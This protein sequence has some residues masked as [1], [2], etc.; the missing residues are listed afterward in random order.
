VFL[1]FR[2]ERGQQGSLPLG[3]ER[4][5]IGRSSECTIVVGDERVSRVH[6]WLENVAGQFLVSDAESSNGTFLNGLRLRSRASCA[7]REGDV[8]EIGGTRFL[9]GTLD[10][11]PHEAVR[12]MGETP[13]A[14]ADLLNDG[15]PDAASALEI[16][17]ELVRAF[18]GAPSS[19]A[20]ERS[21]E[22]VERRL[23]TDGAALFLELPRSPLQCVAARPKEAGH[24][25]AGVARR[26]WTAREGRLL[27]GLWG[28]ADAGAHDT[29]V[30]PLYS[31]GAVPLLQGTT[32]VGVLAAFRLQARRIDRIELAKLA[33]L[34]HEI[35][36][37]LAPG[38]RAAREMALA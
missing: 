16:R 12:E 37:R 3:A 27:H 15:T 7:L 24:A 5:S 26:A 6:A 14:L 22:I 25:L 9:Y 34:G 35:A 33:S 38:T 4:V 28:G 19:A 23:E 11:T 18:A 1:H 32:P 8:I 13:F 29:A 20:L 21:L 36:R 30:R 31:A 2:D 17:A 10:D